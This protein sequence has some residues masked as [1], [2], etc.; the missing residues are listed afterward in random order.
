MT[1]LQPFATKIPSDL[2]KSLDEVCEK[3]GLRRNFIIETALREK[4]E[5]ILDTFDL[6]EAM[7]E[8]TSF[9]SWNSIKKDLK[10]K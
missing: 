6:K 10:L 9:H 1:T 7:E 4:I 2:K 3:F 5:D 8:V